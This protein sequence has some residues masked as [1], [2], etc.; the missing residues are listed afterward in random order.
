[1]SELL[2]EGAIERIFTGHGVSWRAPMVEGLARP[3]SPPAE[4]SRK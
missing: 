2:R 4:E 1:M 3:G